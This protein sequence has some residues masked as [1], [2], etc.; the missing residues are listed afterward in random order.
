M[1]RLILSATALA[2]LLGGCAAL[3]QSDRL[4]ARLRQQEDQLVDY[5]SQIDRLQADLD[6]AQQPA[7]SGIE[8]AS[9]EMPAAG[10]FAAVDS[11]TFAPLVTGGRDT[12][13]DA[14]D[15]QIQALVQPLDPDGDLI[16]TSGALEVE[17]LDVAG[18][19][20]D[21]TIQTWS[22][23]AA[24][25]ARFWDSGLFGSGFRL[26]L[27]P[28]RPLPDDALLIAHFRDRTGR[29][30]DATRAIKLKTG[31]TRPVGQTDAAT[32]ITAAGPVPVERTIPVAIK[33]AAESLPNE[34]TV[35]QLADAVEAAS[36]RVPRPN[37]P[38]A[39]PEKPAADPIDRAN[40]FAE[41]LDE[42]EAKRPIS[43]GP[44]PRTSDRQSRLDDAVI[45]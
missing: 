11:L 3:T 21:R 23:S 40:P 35:P 26:K 18:R 37:A 17:L 9:A 28:D 8:L 29:Q 2:P 27:I 34:I 33:A 30:F 10:G 15:D 25:T 7:A 41:F 36:P 22:F 4:E 24:E 43:R 12:D 16:K 13:G 6:K 31:A 5:R 20:E 45:R 1:R 38:L 42:F 19:D 32:A 39:I 44:L 14:R